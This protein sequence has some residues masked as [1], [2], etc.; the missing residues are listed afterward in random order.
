MRQNSAAETLKSLDFAFAPVI[1]RHAL[2][3][4]DASDP[5]SVDLSQLALKIAH[6]EKRHELLF[7]LDGKSIRTSAIDTIPADL[8]SAPNRTEILE[9]TLRTHL[10]TPEQFEQFCRQLGTQLF[11]AGIPIKIG[12]MGVIGDKT[13]RFLQDVAESIAEIKLTPNVSSEAALLSLRRLHEEI[14]S[15]ADKASQEGTR[16]EDHRRSPAAKEQLSGTLTNVESWALDEQE[17]VIATAVR[18]L[19]DNILTSQPQ[20]LR[21]WLAKNTIFEHTPIA[22][23]ETSGQIKHSSSP[24]AYLL[25]HLTN[26]G[27]VEPFS[28]GGAQLAVNPRGTID[29]KSF[30]DLLPQPLREKLG[31]AISAELSRKYHGKVEPLHAPT[32]EGPNGSYFRDKVRIYRISQETD[33]PS[34][35]V[36]IALRY[37]HGLGLLSAKD[38]G[39]ILSDLGKQTGLGVR[40]AERLGR[41]RSEAQPE[42]SSSDII[43]DFLSTARATREKQSRPEYTVRNHRPGLPR[44]HLFDGFS[45]PDNGI[46]PTLVEA[47]QRATHHADPTQ[48]LVI[49]GGVLSPERGMRRKEMRNWTAPHSEGEKTKLGAALIAEYP[50]RTLHL[51]G[52]RDDQSA[53]RRAYEQALRERAYT[54]SDG[55]ASPS[56]AAIRASIEH[57]NDQ[58]QYT[59]QQELAAEITKWATFI[60]LVVQP[61]EWKLGR[62]LHESDTIHAQTGVEMN[63]LEIV[64]SISQTMRESGS[65]K[66][67]LP[68]LSANYQSYLTFACA[69]DPV[70]LEKLERVLFPKKE[71]FTTQEAVTRGGADLVML[72]PHQRDPRYR[73]AAVTDF[74]RSDRAPANPTSAYEGLLRSMGN[75]RHD[76]ADM[77]LLYGTDQ[78][79][80]QL[81]PHG[82]VITAG[83]MQGVSDARQ[84]DLHYQLHSRAFKDMAGRGLPPQASFITLQGGVHSHKITQAIEYQ[85]TTPKLLA[86]IEDNIKRGVPHKQAHIYVTSDWQIGSPTMQPA[87]IVAG[88]IEAIDVGVEEIVLNGDILHGVNYPRFLQ[89][90]QLVEHPLNGIDSQSQYIFEL[91][92][93][94]LAY[95]RA[96]KEADRSFKIPTFTILP[97]NHEINTQANKGTQGTWFVQGI[98]EKV[99]SYLHGWTNDETFSNAHVVCPEKFIA[100]D[101]TPVDYPLVHIDRTKDLG[102]CVEVTHYNA[103]GGGG[104]FSPT[105]TGIAR[106]IHAMGEG[107]AHIRLEGHLHVTGFQVINGVVCV[108]TGANAGQSSYEAHLGFP[109]APPSNQFISLDSHN[110]PTFFVATQAYQET[111]YRDLLG[112]LHEKGILVDYN[113]FDAFCDEKRRF[114]SLRDRGNPTDV[115]R[116]S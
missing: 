64:A 84:P 21:R 58:R 116:G 10:T 33:V 95:M 36:T 83:T 91:L 82:W 113:T 35:L 7:P 77:H 3:I 5:A 40:V 87:M 1:G 79:I 102:I 53:E 30:E 97:G 103:K 111:R 57:R 67:A 68:E 112:K 51:L 16:G 100:S 80:G 28:V 65:L 73:V 72:G 98:A 76:T 27:I 109:P 4:A 44:T 47:S 94:V 60:S 6:L 31:R 55:A 93:P 92:N 41:P 19:E 78:L 81:G 63:E 62:R 54:T 26:L 38:G 115:R 45:I 114:V 50:G 52:R 101:G 86:A 90:S 20:K 71:E 110:L 25:H 42:G 70:I 66:K 46:D 22:A 39:L 34:S 13:A 88:L 14:I 15:F 104:A 106:H 85:I 12:R 18:S 37:Y 17:R 69:E 8:P 74:K 56:E 61:L 96:K 99:R 29:R 2:G 75:L 23:D 107:K 32:A 9:R 48:Q 59:Q 108:R 24:K 11:E 89:E 49:V 43:D 105:V